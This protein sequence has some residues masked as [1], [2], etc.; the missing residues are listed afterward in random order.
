MYV[1]CLNVE[2]GKRVKSVAL[3]SNKKKGK[4][5]KKKSTR[6]KKKKV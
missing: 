5:R 1:H 3:R 6:E 4:K 2:F